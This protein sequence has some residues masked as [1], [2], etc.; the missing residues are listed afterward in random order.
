MNM[1]RRLIQKRVDM[2]GQVLEE[3][4]SPGK[5]LVESGNDTGTFSCGNKRVCPR[6]VLLR[7]LGG[8]SFPGYDEKRMESVRGVFI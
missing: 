2:V 6:F 3:V 4:F 7:I 1:K 8:E 5:N